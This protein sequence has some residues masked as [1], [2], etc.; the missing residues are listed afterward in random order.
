ML[1]LERRLMTPAT[2][3]LELPRLTTDETNIH[4]YIYMYIP[5]LMQL[6]I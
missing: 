1:Q 4:I 5:A 3:N 6:Y 2:A